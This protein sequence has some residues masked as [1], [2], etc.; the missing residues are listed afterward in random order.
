MGYIGHGSYLETSYASTSWTEY[1]ELVLLC[2][3]IC[4]DYLV[5]K[6]W[7]GAINMGF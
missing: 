1:L 3:A 2:L 7:R 6:D 5:I 4:F